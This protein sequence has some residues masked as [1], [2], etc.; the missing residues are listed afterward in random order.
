MSTDLSP[1]ERQ[2]ID[3]IA[4]GRTTKE[5]AAELSIKESTVN[6]HVSNART[7]LGASTR[8]EA[9]AIA[10]RDSSPDGTEVMRHPGSR[11]GW[12]AVAFAVSG[13]LCAFLLGAGAVAAGLHRPAAT[14]QSS[15]SVAPASA[16]PAT[17]ATL[18]SPEARVPLTAT[19]AP[20]VGPVAP[21]GQ[22]TAVPTIALPSIPVPS[23]PIPLIPVPTLPPLR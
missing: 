8:A 18:E 16:T 10:M 4:S 21:T 13:V 17:S 22:P 19:A 23:I 12:R 9:V 7:K 14:P 11:A 6:W 5:I 20:S 3:Q 2:A 1:R 15:A